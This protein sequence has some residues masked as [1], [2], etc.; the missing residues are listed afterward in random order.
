MLAVSLRY[1][2]NFLRVQTMR[3][4]DIRRSLLAEIEERHRGETDTL[5]KEE[6]GLCQGLARVDIAVVN[7]SVHGYEIKSEQDTLARL[8]GQ[9]QIYSRALDFVTIVTAPAHAKKISEVVPGWWGICNATEF[10]QEVRLESSR[11]AF[12]NPQVEPFALA[13]FL[14]RDEALQ[15]LSENNLAAGMRS[16]RREQLWH[17]LASELTLEKLG[18][19]VRERLKRRR[20]DWRVPATPA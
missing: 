10:G 8:P 1:K 14:W 15:A 11:E 17:R 18:C 9:A 3:E 20:V 13:Q 5:I 2:I 6:L 12:H 4:I 16:K 7:G 19:I